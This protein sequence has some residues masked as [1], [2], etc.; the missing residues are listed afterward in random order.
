[1]LAPLSQATSAHR[2]RK[3]DGDSFRTQ[4]SMRV[5]NPFRP[6]LVKIFLT[7]EKNIAGVKTQVKASYICL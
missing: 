4:W 6:L 5:E 1:M 2:D 3:E 7:F